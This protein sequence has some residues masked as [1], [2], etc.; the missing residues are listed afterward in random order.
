MIS[1]LRVPVYVLKIQLN[2]QNELSFAISC[3]LL[4]IFFFDPV[5]PFLG[6]K[7]Q[8]PKKS[9]YTVRSVRLYFLIASP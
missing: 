5:L 6:R 9:A 8:D 7:Q 2:Q 1:V 3:V 4:V